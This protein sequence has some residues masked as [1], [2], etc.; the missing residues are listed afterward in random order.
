MK[1]MFLSFLMVILSRNGQI[2]SSLNDICRNCC[3]NFEIGAVLR[4]KQ[5][6]WALIVQTKVVVVLLLGF[7]LSKKFYS[8]SQMSPSICFLFR[9]LHWF[10]SHSLLLALTRCPVVVSCS[11]VVWARSVRDV[12]VHSLLQHEPGRQPGPHH[13]HGAVSELQLEDDPVLLW[14]D[15]CG[16]VLHLPA[17]DQE[18]TKGRGAA[19]CGNCS[20]EKQRGWGWCLTTLKYLSTLQT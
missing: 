12:V 10:S 15:L 13:C 7:F 14:D 5:S 18:W 16:H 17:G 3:R 4:G 11:S 2:D 6:T 1:C 19:Q 20:Q 8:L 9:S